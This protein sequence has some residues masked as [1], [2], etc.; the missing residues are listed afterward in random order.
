MA[1]EAARA[2][3][4]LRARRARA[5]P[6]ALFRGALRALGRLRCAL[7]TVRR[8]RRTSLPCCGL[9]TCLPTSTND[10]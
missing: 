4:A 9:Y 5:G 2:R 6:R 10:F 3:A 1:Q 8:P 7:P